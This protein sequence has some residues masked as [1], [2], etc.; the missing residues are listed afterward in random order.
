MA[1]FR[2]GCHTLTWGNY[3]SGYPIKDALWEIREAG[4][5]GVEIYDPL[6]RLG[7]ASALKMQLEEQGL[8][9]AAV[10]ANIK[11]SADEKAD[12]AEAKEKVFFAGQ[13]GVKALMATGGW[14]GEGLKKEP[15]SYKS[16]CRR[17]DLLAAYASK[18]D[19]QVAFHNHLDT[20]VEDERDILNLLEFSKSL[21]L[22]IDTGHLAAAGSDPAY[23]LEK[24][25]SS[26]ALVH[27]KDWDPGIRDF[28]EL[29]RGVIGGG[30]KNVLETLEKINYTN[31]IIIE[32]D[33]TLTTPFESARI[34]RDFLRGIGY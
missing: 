10:S 16:L 24:Y 34:S 14:S 17:L 9:L 12:L 7:P 25:A 2:I 4:Y 22:C 3:L 27:L 5:D 31:W 20:I 28:T 26:L 6:S 29:G 19:M 21:K 33:R 15:K 18:F 13:F 30:M 23:V 1:R 11:V 8:A 32:L